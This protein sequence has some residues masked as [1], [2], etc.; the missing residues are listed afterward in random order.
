MFLLKLKLCFG[1][2]VHMSPYMDFESIWVL[3]RNWGFRWWW[4]LLLCST[5]IWF[6]SFTQDVVLCLSSVPAQLFTLV[7]LSICHPTGLNLDGSY[8]GAT[9][10]DIAGC[11]WWLLLWSYSS[12][13]SSIPGIEQHICVI[14]C[15]TGYNF[16]QDLPKIWDSLLYVCP[17]NL[18]TMELLQSTPHMAPGFL[19]VAATVQFTAQVTWGPNLTRSKKRKILTPHQSQ[20]YIILSP[21]QYFFLG[22]YLLRFKSN[23]VTMLWP[24]IN[25]FLKCGF[26]S[27]RKC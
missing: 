25:N 16:H 7:L 27:F 13:R 4:L 15:S 22:S 3:V 20:V 1:L 18:Q 5:L 9:L 8:K 17:W 10:L 2:W 6:F 26:F 21:N 12:T 11:Y 24:S 19:P 14:L 23:S